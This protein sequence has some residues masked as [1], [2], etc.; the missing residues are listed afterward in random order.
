[1]YVCSSRK[2]NKIPKPKTTIIFNIFFFFLHSNSCSL[3]LLACMKWI[4]IWEDNK[5]S[6]KCF[7][8]W[9]LIR[10]MAINQSKI[11]LLTSSC[12]FSFISSLS[13]PHTCYF[14]RMLQVI[15]LK[16]RIK[17]KTIR[18]YIFC[19]TTAKTLQCWWC[20]WRCVYTYIKSA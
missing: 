20:R 7:C 12:S 16:P 4:H 18:L 9:W 1:M 11:M 14:Y 13:L 17:R 6:Y 3:S 10:S 8:W 5:Y 15:F 2:A 19:K